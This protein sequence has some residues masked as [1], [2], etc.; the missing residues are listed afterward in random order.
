MLL[1]FGGESLLPASELGH[2][3]GWVRKPE[4]LPKSQLQCTEVCRT[5]RTQVRPRLCITIAAARATLMGHC[6]SREHG[7]GPVLR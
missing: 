4:R 6:S 7:V 1:F 3:V 2:G 5:T